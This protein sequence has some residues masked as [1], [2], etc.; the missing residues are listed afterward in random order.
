MIGKEEDGV[1]EEEVDEEDDGVTL[2]VAVERCDAEVLELRYRVTNGS[3]QAIYLTTPLTEVGDDGKLVAAPE[4]VY[5]YVDD[6]GVLHITKRVWPVPEGVDVYVEEVPRL[7]RV[8]AGGWFEERVVLKVPVVVR[9]PYRVR[10]D[11]MTQPILANVG[12][13]VISIGYQIEI[14]G[15]H[16]LISTRCDL[17]LVA[18]LIQ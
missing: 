5:T 18:I 13:A 2:Q 16:D 17:A 15:N 12:D 6:E 8:E 4:K 11:K 14:N 9:Y 1:E 3:D 10:D 7:T